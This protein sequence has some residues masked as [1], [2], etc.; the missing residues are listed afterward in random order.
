MLQATGELGGLTE[1]ITFLVS[2]APQYASQLVDIVNK[3]GSYLPQIQTIVNKAGSQIPKIATIVDKGAK[4]IPTLLSIVEDPALP[5]VIARVQ[6]LKTITAREAA[7]APKS[8]GAAVSSAGIGLQKAIKPLDAY[9]WYR[10]N[11][12]TTYALLGLGF[13]A[14]IGGSFMA[15]RRS[16]RCR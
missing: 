8:P 13:V 12:G 10:E 7:S 9:I 11:P 14:I 15:G 16:K 3:A 4:Y 5:Q 1:D 6:T 2:K